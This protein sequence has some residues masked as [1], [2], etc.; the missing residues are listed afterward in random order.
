MLLMHIINDYI[1]TRSTSPGRFILEQIVFCPLQMIPTAIGIMLRGFIYRLLIQNRGL[2]GIE[3]NVQICHSR[4][5]KL[6]KNVYIGRNVYIGASGGGIL[7]EDDVTILDN[8]YLNV[9]DYDTTAGKCILLEPRVVLSCGCVIHGQSG[10][11]IGEGTIVGP[12]TTFVTGN[13]GDISA[14][15][16]YRDTGSSTDTPIHVGANVWIGTN[17]AVLPG[18]TIGDNSVIGAGS[19]V[20]RDVPAFS[21]FAGNPAKF[22]RTVQ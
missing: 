13:H 10:V 19:V 22:V 8:C 12:N 14:H 5:L 7:L 6:G 3:E 20:T 1:R 17:A 2:F 11:K 21:V 4:Q 9:F 16:K 15:T 18:I